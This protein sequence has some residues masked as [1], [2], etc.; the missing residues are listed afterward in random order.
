MLI[1]YCNCK[2]YN[3]YD[4]S[5]L[6]TEV[7][8][9]VDSS[10]SNINKEFIYIF[11]RMIH[12]EPCSY[13]DK[14]IYTE[15][16][17]LLESLYQAHSSRLKIDEKTFNYFSMGY[18][19]FCQISETICDLGSFNL[20][21]ELKTRLYRLPTYTS[22][23]ESCLSNFLRVIARLIGQGAGKDY[24]AQ[25]TLGQLV[26]V[27]SSNGYTQLAGNIDVN[28]RNAINHGKVRL[29]KDPIDKIYFYY[30]EQRISK[31]KEI[32]LYE[33][34]KIID[35]SFDTASAVLLALST[36]MNF[37]MHLICIDET[38]NEYIPFV[39]L[40][41]KLSI[42]GIYCS[43]ISDTGNLNQLNIELEVENTERGNIAQI[44]ALLSILVYNAHSDYDKYLFS[45]SNPRMMSGWIIYHK[46]D[47]IDIISGTKKIDTVCSEII[48]RKDFLIFP[49]ST[50]DIDLNEVKYFCFPNYNSTNYKIN[51]IANASTPDRKRLRANL[52]VP[53]AKNRNDL[54][55]IIDQAIEWL[56]T[57]KNPA[58]PT[59]VQKHGDMPADALYINVYYNDGRKCKELTPSNDNFICFVDYNTD[60][61]TTLA[62]GGLPTSI[63]KTFYHEKIDNKLIAWRTREYATIRSGEIGKNSLCPCGSGKKYKRCCGSSK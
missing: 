16:F 46:Q 6:L 9:N 45:F 42:P 25:N 24:S 27:I 31:T 61:T 60:G 20:S 38:K 34:D 3:E 37:H 5:T 4:A 53:N 17:S 14:N 54:L 28:I 44:A 39:I 50:E 22:I 48:E 8:H 41:M 12:T 13:W 15:V 51:N 21:H 11:H 26:N 58:S 7:Q 63:W 52:F 33:F 55:T 59:L 32:A 40:A 30:S 36:F 10:I 1:T 35:K 43:S 18:N 29:S 57:V 49:P 19:A 2:Y 62:N 23:I 47:I 56:L